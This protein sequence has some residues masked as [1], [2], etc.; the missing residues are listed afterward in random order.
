[1]WKYQDK[2]KDRSPDVFE[3]DDNLLATIDHKILLLSLMKINYLFDKYRYFTDNFIRLKRENKL[4]GDSRIFKL[5]LGGNELSR[6]A[7]MATD[8][9]ELS[10]IKFSPIYLSD[11]ARRAARMRT[12]VRKGI[13]PMVD[14]SHLVDHCITHE[15]DHLLEGTCRK[16]F[17]LNNG[18][19]R[20]GCCL[21]GI[22]DENLKLLALDFYPY[23][24]NDILQGLEGNSRSISK[25][26][27][28]EPLEFFAEAFAHLECTDNPADVNEIGRRLE[29]YLVNTMQC[30]P[31][32]N[33]KFNR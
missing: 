4:P 2:Y 32:E 29:N 20:G 30:L 23:V 21:D 26:G 6:T 9:S 28:T 11:Y 24:E 15:F 1:M 27:D 8:V 17:I 13:H 25:Y 16:I 7:V 10:F 12:F 14:D 5:E 33:S 19:Y 18:G 3:F 22:A 31:R